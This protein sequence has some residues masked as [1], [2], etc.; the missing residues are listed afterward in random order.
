MK[1]NVG[2]FFGGASVEHDISIL[3][4]MQAMAALN[5]DRY[6][7]VPLYLNKAGTLVSGKAL[8]DVKTFKSSTLIQKKSTPVSL[9]KSG[10]F[11][12]MK[13]IKGWGK[14][15][16]LDVIL[17]VVHGTNSED[18][19]VAGYLNVLGAVYGGS[20]VIA[21]AI[22]Q[23]KVIFKH[24]C[25]N[26]R[27]PIVP[28]FWFYGQDKEVSKV[29]ILTQAK[30]L[31]YPLI[32][33][34]S[35]L[36]S[37][38]GIE[39]VNS[40]AELFSAIERASQFDEKI[41]VEKAIT[42]LREINCSVLKKKGQ[43]IA[44]VCEEVSKSDDILS[45]QDKYQ[46]SGKGKH[47]GPSKGMASLDRIIPAPISEELTREIQDLATT[48]ARLLNVGGVVRIDFLLDTQNNKVYINEINTIPG[49]LSF[50]L[51]QASGIDFETLMDILVDGAIEREQRKEKL[52]LTF[53]S[54]V[55]EGFK[56]TKKS[57]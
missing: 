51:W 40:E 27:L 6:H 33:K 16:R 7:V 12:Y 20:D 11:V 35:N 13:P 28:W 10:Q 19:S 53:E 9:Y 54:S 48:C 37:S 46:R 44:S 18:G 36:G 22:G 21:A 32:I 25:E 47:S 8:S 29:A 24:I 42:H 43:H 55:L 49:S 45:F 26:S 41:V 14:P 3:S 2:V 30:Q 56:G 31:G 23:D 5:Q 50:Y 17:P 4:A 39:L 34:P 1:L 57:S 38:V 52:T 15:I